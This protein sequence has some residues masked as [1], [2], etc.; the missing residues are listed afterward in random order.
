MQENLSFVVFEVEEKDRRISIESKII[1]TLS[2]DKTI[3]SEDWLGNYSIQPKIKESG[4]W[5]VQEL[6]KE[7]LTQE[8]FEELKQIVLS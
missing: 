6:Y 1:S 2:N 5:L 3:P 7:N 8:E 4:L